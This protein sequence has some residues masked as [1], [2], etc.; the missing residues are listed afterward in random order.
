M[1]GNITRIV[2]NQLILGTPMDDEKYFDQLAIEALRDL[3]IALGLPG[4]Y[5]S[6]TSVSWGGISVSFV[7]STAAGS[8]D[9]PTLVSMYESGEKF[10][11]TQQKLIS[12]NSDVLNQAAKTTFAS[13]PDY[14]KKS[15]AYDYFMDK[16]SKHF[17]MTTLEVQNRLTSDEDE[18]DQNLSQDARLLALKE[19]YI[20]EKTV[21]VASANVTGTTSTATDATVSGVEIEPDYGISGMVGAIDTSQDTDNKPF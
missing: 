4:S 6:K 17:G 21:S 18:Y 7:P 9:V 14:N 8:W 10:T 5:T 1:D 13:I 3:D 16:V 19:N 2:V 20:G 12:D 11:L 15:S